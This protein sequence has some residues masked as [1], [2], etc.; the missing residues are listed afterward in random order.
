[1]LEL[2]QKLGISQSRLS[3][4]EQGKGELSAEQLINAMKLFNLPL[5]YFVQ[6]PK[7]NIEIKLQNA[8]AR[9]GSQLKEHPDMLPSEQ[10]EKVYQVISETIIHGASSR[11]LISLGPVIVNH[12]KQVQFDRIEKQLREFHLENRLY[13]IIEGILRSIN[14]RLEVYLP[15]EVSLRYRKAKV[16]LEPRLS[17]P[18][19]VFAVLG[20]EVP[21]DILDADI[22]SQKTLEE[23]KTSRDELARKWKIVTRITEKD[24][25]KT[26]VETEKND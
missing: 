19:S 6:F 5:G 23:I 9:L 18:P 11:L 15:R 20:H 1:Q 24:F 17:I 2:A 4:I 21:E 8:V 25:L 10:L 22:S 7:E 14:K 13:W 26:L 3:E 16:V 12:I